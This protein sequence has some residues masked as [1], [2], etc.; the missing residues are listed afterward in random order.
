M[1]V[2]EVRLGTTKNG[3]PRTLALNGAPLG[4]ARPALEGQGVSDQE[5]LRN[6]GLR[7][8]SPRRTSDLRLGL[9]EGIRRCLR[10]G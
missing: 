10:R 3:R 8:S 1:T 2:R 6:R 7:V 9:P 4:A 5:E